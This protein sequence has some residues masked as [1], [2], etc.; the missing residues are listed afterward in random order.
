MIV[1]GVAATRFSEK[2]YVTQSRERPRLAA[3]RRTTRA[4]SIGASSCHGQ[5]ET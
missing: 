3:D 1:L 4:S 5:G 2:L